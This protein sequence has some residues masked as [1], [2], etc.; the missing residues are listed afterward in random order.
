MTLLNCCCQ[1]C[2]YCLPGLTINP[3]KSPPNRIVVD[4][5]SAPACAAAFMYPGTYDI[6]LTKGPG[7]CPNLSGSATNGFQTA[8]ALLLNT[9]HAP[10]T[11]CS[12]SCIITL[13]D[14]IFCWN[15]SAWDLSA[16]VGGTCFTI[17]DWAGRL[18][19]T[20]HF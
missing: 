19:I 11:P 8:N 20:N 16:L 2:Q 15:G 4:I 9:T 1:G 17:G 7:P 12:N 5:L 10:V 6:T 14:L 13:A 18:T 3:D